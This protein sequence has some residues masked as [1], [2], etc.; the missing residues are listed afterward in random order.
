MTKKDYELA[1]SMLSQ[2]FPGELWRDERETVTRFCQSF[3][4]ADNHGFNA[5]TFKSI[6]E[7]FND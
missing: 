2:M 7:S 4:A 3:F 1:A 6:I 5:T